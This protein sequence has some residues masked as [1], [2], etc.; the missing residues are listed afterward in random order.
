MNV[1]AIILAGGQGSGL[2]VLTRVR[3]KPALP[4]AGKY[5]IIDFVLSNLVNSHLQRV[6]VLVQYNPH[7]LLKHLGTGE[8][9]GLNEGGHNGLRIWQPGLELYRGT[10]DAVY[11]NRKFIADEGSDLVLITSGDQMYRQDY[12]GMIRFHQERG[13][14][15]T[16]A[17]LEV[18]LEEGRRFGLM[19]VDS[20]RRI[21]SFIEKPEQPSTTLASL[22]TYLFNTSFLLRLFEENARKPEPGADFGRDI[23]PEIIPGRQAYAYP[24]SG[25]WM[26]F[27]TV[28]NYWKANLALLD[29]PL[30]INLRDSE[31]IYHTRP[32]EKPPVE[33]RQPGQ[34]ADSLVSDGCVISGQVIH[35]VL[36]PGVVIEQGAQVK[37]SVILNDAI[38]R[39]GAKVDRCVIDKEVVIGK[40]ARVGEGIDNPPNR[41][42]PS[43][44][45]DGITLVGKRAVIPSG[46]VIGRNCRIDPYARAEDFQDL[47]VPGGTSIYYNHGQP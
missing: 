46:A 14:Q 26:D 35:S 30:A 13:A 19:Q 33:V 11:Q 42:E 28:L 10:A 39:C 47:H 20:D 44:L 2:S 6:A 36:S 37:D 16:I 29:Q 18:P 45:F 21:T 9:W 17:A 38:I 15:L 12:R 24:F 23:I 25:Y 31:W 34:I 22:G 4:F 5:R 41:D 27:G 1:L 32:V 7:S 3:A 43:I 40:N 8:P